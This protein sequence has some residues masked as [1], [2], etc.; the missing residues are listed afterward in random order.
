LL[1]SK[2]GASIEIGS[3]G[4]STLFTDVTKE[5]CIHHLFAYL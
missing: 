1:Q 4:K 3:R 5:G 2:H